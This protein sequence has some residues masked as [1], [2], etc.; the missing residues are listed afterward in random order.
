MG[1]MNKKLIKLFLET[2]VFNDD[3][4][5]VSKDEAILN[6]ADNSRLNAKTYGKKPI[7]SSTHKS[8]KHGKYILQI[9]EYVLPAS[10]KKVNVVVFCLVDNSIAGYIRAEIVKTDEV[11]SK[12]PTIDISLVKDEYQGDGMGSS[13][14]AALMTNYGGMKSDTTLTGE[15]GKGSFDIWEKL[16]NKYNSYLYDEDKGKIKQVPN[17]TRKMMVNKGRNAYIRFLVTVA[18]L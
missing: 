6:G 18:P 17:F 13:M 8:L 4:K 14:Y 9:W 5:A 1:D 10:P 16:G 12:F 11:V 3:S 15:S 7:F 2:P